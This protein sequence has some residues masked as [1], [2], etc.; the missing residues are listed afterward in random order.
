[1]RHVNSNS[2]MWPQLSRYS[3]LA[4]WKWKG[5]AWVGGKDRERRDPMSGGDRRPDVCGDDAGVLIEH[6]GDG[7]LKAVEA[8]AS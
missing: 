8:V 1:M 3:P 4:N 5:P 6:E 2:Q 7:S